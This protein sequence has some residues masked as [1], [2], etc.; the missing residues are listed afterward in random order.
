VRRRRDPSV[1]TTDILPGV[2][3]VGVFDPERNVMLNWGS[4]FFVDQSLGLVVT[5]G[6][7]VFER[8]D[9]NKPSFGQPF[10]GC[11]NAQAVVAVIP[12]KRKT[13][14]V[15]RYFADIII[16]DDVP[17]VDACVLRISSRMAT[18]GAFHG[19]TKPICSTQIP[20]ERICELCTT[21]D[22]QLGEGVRIVGY[23]QGGEGRFEPGKHVSLS[24]DV[25][26]GNLC[27][28]FDAP[29][30][31]LNGLQSYITKSELVTDCSTRVGH[32]G[33]PCINSEGKV[34]GILSRGDPV[35]LNRSYLVPASLIQP[36]V[37]SAKR[38]CAKI[39]GV[40]W[41]MPKLA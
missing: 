32:S 22:F 38:L 28:S 9:K 30:E 18:D 21:K 13:E 14:A 8:K 10:F 23:D 5:A 3:L 39:D 36:M 26:F 33:G 25:A 16:Y 19:P 1:N 31:A 17:Y 20:A 27:R 12:D 4:G 11:R 37:A 35:Q 24:V 15:F 7:V 41:K 2:V 40:S 34:I 29:L 6:H